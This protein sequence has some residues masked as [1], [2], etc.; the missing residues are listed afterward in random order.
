MDGSWCISYATRARKVTGSARSAVRGGEDAGA[1]EVAKLADDRVFDPEA[2]ADSRGRQEADT[3]SE[4]RGRAQM[5]RNRANAVPAV[6]CDGGDVA[7]ENFDLAAKVRGVEMSVRHLHA[8]QSGRATEPNRADDP[9]KDPDQHRD[10]ARDAGHAHTSHELQDSKDP[11][12]IEE[13]R[14]DKAEPPRFARRD[15]GAHEP[16]GV[17]AA[18]S[19]SDCATASSCASRA[20]LLVRMMNCSPTPWRTTVFGVST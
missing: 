18:D 1:G 19:F 17:F 10:R 9:S 6:L 20:A 4:R 14:T 3:A 15:L 8:H 16:Y 13:C 12:E 2:K 7:G 11:D 5:D